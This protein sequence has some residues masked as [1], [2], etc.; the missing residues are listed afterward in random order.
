M[1]FNFKRSAALL[2][3]SICAFATAGLALPSPSSP[4]NE[5][6]I[7]PATESNKKLGET[8]RISG[9]LPGPR[10]RARDLT[11]LEIAAIR[12]NPGR[13][14]FSRHKQRSKYM[15]HVGAKQNQAKSGLIG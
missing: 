8:I 7:A 3:A 4:G 9:G 15:P 5:A 14:L 6:R 12:T 1:T 13:H 2:A 10:I 11:G